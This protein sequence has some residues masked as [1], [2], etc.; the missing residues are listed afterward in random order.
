M[1]S[2][3]DN[4]NLWIKIK[5]RYILKDVF[6]NLAQNKKLN[7]IKYNKFIQKIFDIK[8]NDY[9]ECNN[10]L[11]QN[12]R[13]MPEFNSDPKNLKEESILIDEAGFQNTIS[14]NTFIIFKSFHDK[15]YLVYGDNS[16]IIISYDLSTN[17]KLK[18]V[19]KTNEV[20]SCFNH[21]P[22]IYNKR[23]LIMTIHSKSNSIKVWD[24]RDMKLIYYFNK[25]NKSGYLNIACF[26]NDNNQIY[27]MSSNHRYTGKN[28]DPIKI[29]DLKGNKIKELKDSD[30]NVSF[31][32]YY[33][34]KRQFKKYIIAG[35]SKYIRAYDPTNNSIYKIYKDKYKSF[36]R[37]VL[38]NDYENITKLIESSSDGN[39]RIWDF[40]KAELIKRIKINDKGTFGICLW[41]KESL[42]V[43]TKDKIVLVNI[44][45]SEIIYE[46]SYNF[47][48]E[49]NDYG[50]IA[51]KKLNSINFGECLLTKAY[52][53]DAIKILS[54][55][56]K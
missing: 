4:N 26:F 3:K 29:Y 43:G 52:D 1:I 54:A 12:M 14:S 41:N 17:T 40:H 25:I 16:N 10:I 32:D 7:V 48:R 42:F 6:Y 22:D 49:Y 19:Q 23:D 27:I 11:I 46:Y 35:F 20:T 45:T 50:I 31:L 8:L 28:V 15:Y 9:K 18:Q 38:I 39:I 53:N 36:H 5:S 47:K 51:I 44:N 21:Y 24:F 37:E 33:Y 30:E 13:S 56:K 34:D 2:K 55:Q